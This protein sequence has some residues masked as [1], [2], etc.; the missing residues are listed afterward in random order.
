MQIK[1]GPT[2]VGLLPD[3]QFKDLERGLPSSSNEALK[4]TLAGLLEQEARGE[5]VSARI[6]AICRRLGV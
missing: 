3:W 1:L 6:L 4:A 5:D 2:P